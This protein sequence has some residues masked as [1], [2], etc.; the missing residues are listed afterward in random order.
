MA[1]W[2]KSPQVLLQLALNSV[3]RFPFTI[4]SGLILTAVGIWAVRIGVAEK[5]YQDEFLS[6]LLRV[7][8]TASLSLPL[9]FTV[10]LLLENNLN[11]NRIFRLGLINLLFGIL[12]FVYF[13]LSSYQQSINVEERIWLRYWSYSVVFHLLA[14]ILPV[15]NKKNSN[16]VWQYNQTLFLRTFT[17]A[18]YC[19]VLYTGLAG[20]MLALDQL[21]G[22]EIKG[23]YYAYL[24]FIMLGLVSTL[25]FVSGIP[26]GVQ[27]QDDNQNFPKPLKVFAQYVL[28]PLVLIY[29]LILYAYAGQILVQWKLPVG[30]VSN[31]ILSFAVAGM[32]ALLLLYPFGTNDRWIH[33]YSRGY[34]I[35]LLPL[36]ILLFVAAG[37]R[38]D[39]YGF[40]VLRYSL[41]ALAIWLTAISI[42]MILTKNKYIGMI[43]FSLAVT[44][45]LV[46]FVPGIN[47]WSVSKRDQTQRIQEEFKKAGIFDGKQL[48]QGVILS[49]SAS[50]RLHED[51]MYMF[52]QHNITGLEPA[53][54][55]PEMIANDTGKLVKT[56]RIS[57]WE[58]KSWLSD[59]LKVYG[60]RDE[61]DRYNT[62][63]EATEVE[64]PAT[65]VDSAVEV[66]EH[67]L[68]ISGSAS[69]ARTNLNIPAGNWK[70]LVLIN[71]D[72]DE[73]MFYGNGDDCDGLFTRIA[74][75]NSLDYDGSFDSLQIQGPGLNDKYAFYS[76]LQ[77]K[78]PNFENI[79]I[80]KDTRYNW[81]DEG[82]IIQ[83]KNSILA[84][85]YLELK[86]S[87]K[88]KRFLPYKFSGMV[89]VK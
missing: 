53:L 39:E 23:H 26:N 56:N 15:V 17:T 55:L 75:G 24:M 54:V 47:A 87:E 1:N 36:L 84:V 21:F 16:A 18:L 42:F 11:R 81:G 71:P 34:Y 48:K 37:I 6:F 5:Q 77:K 82:M 43:P 57:T 19:G 88:C 67:I 76:T 31:M 89:W 50:D 83:G 73:T 7:G 68:T 60:V 33:H 30:W 27:V 12:I 66:P 72:K 44:A 78:F 10:H 69:S 3:K 63:A 4:F 20:A 8:M 28:L 74:D 86:Y 49:D 70:R 35:A 13:D 59:T 32:L 61:Y 2:F 38:I 62:I 14:A 25:I 41:L 51:V 64:V 65:V 52:D 79:K 46:F 45:F 85:H 22:L 40:T 58:V 9:S 29:L 80:N